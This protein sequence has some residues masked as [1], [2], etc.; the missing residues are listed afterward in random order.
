MWETVRIAADRG[1]IGPRS[2]THACANILRELVLPGAEAVVLGIYLTRQ[3]PDHEIADRLYISRRTASKHVE[4][5]LAKLGVASR[6]E[7]AAE[8]RRHG[9]R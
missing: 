2:F 8:A 9:L 6:R 4:A 1:P 3:R 5:I 7:A